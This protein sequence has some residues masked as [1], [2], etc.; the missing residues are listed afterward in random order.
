VKAD[1]GNPEA[2]MINFV[3]PEGIHLLNLAISNHQ[4][5]HNT[6]LWSRILSNTS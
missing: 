4:I 6:D 2:E 5:H 3:L 1:G